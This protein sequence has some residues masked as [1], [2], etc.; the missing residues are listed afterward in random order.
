MIIAL[1]ADLHGNMTAVEALERDL[2]ARG[3]QTIWCLGDVVGKGPS[4]GRT[5]DWALANCQVILRGNWDEGIGAA[6]FA[7]DAFYYAQL[8]KQR[9]AKLMDFPIEKRLRLSGRTIRLIHGR[10]TMQELVYPQGSAETLQTLFDPDYDVVGYADTHRQGLRM[11]KGILFNTGS[12]G[13]GMGLNMIQYAIIEGQEGHA[14][15][16]FD[17]RLVCLPY[18][19]QGAVRETQLQPE[20]P[21]GDLFIRELQT[22]VYARHGGTTGK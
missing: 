15:A 18:D 6:Q 3:L 7:N 17:I 11:L 2:K 5:F 12:V 16:A 13:N 19:I 22:G 10:P 1:I 4:S 8:G 21:N 14:Q 20:L 9:L